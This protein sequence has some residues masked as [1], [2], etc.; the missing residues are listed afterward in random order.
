MKGHFLRINKGF[1]KDTMRLYFV[2]AIVFSAIS[3]FIAYAMGCD[4]CDYDAS[5][6]H[7]HISTWH[8]QTLVCVFMAYLGANLARKLMDMNVAEVYASIP[9]SRDNMWTAH[10]LTGIIYSIMIIAAS[11]IGMLLGE[12]SSAISVGQNIGSYGYSA[13][14]YMT[15]LCKI[16][17]EGLISFA[18][19]GTAF[20]ITGK[21]FAGIVTAGIGYGSIVILFLSLFGT[22]NLD[23]LC[24]LIFPFSAA[25]RTAAAWVVYIMIVIL[26][27]LLF[28]KMFLTIRTES[29][30]HAFRNMRI[31]TIVGLILA[32]SILG[33][34]VLTVILLREYAGD[35]ISDIDIIAESVIGTVIACLIAYFGFMWIS[36]RSFK[37]AAVSLK[38]LPI[39]LLAVCVVA[40][41]GSGL[42]KTCK[43][44]DFSA[45]NIAYYTIPN[46]VCTP[47]ET[48]WYDHF[49]EFNMFSMTYNDY[50]N[51]HYGKGVSCEDKIRFTDQKMIN[52][53]SKYLKSGENTADV[54]QM[55]G[56]PSIYVTLKNGKTYAVSISD[57]EIRYEDNAKQNEEYRKVMYDIEPFKGG[58][59]VLENRRA[60]ALYD[61]FME[62]LSTL[63]IEEREKL[64]DLSGIYYS[65]TYS[66][67]D[68]FPDTAINDVDIDIFKEA[69]FTPYARVLFIANRSNSLIRGIILN[70]STPKTLEAYLKLS[71]EL[72]AKDKKFDRVLELL[73]DE[74][75]DVNVRF[76][77]MIWDRE[78]QETCK[79]SVFADSGMSWGPSYLE[80]SDE[81]MEM[82]D[83]FLTDSFH[84]SID[85]L[86]EQE[87]QMVYYTLDYTTGLSY[88][89]Q[90]GSDE[91][92]LTDEIR[93]E[94]LNK[95][96]GMEDEDPHQ[97]EYNSD[98]RDLLNLFMHGGTDIDSYRYVITIVS[99]DITGM[100]LRDGFVYDYVESWMMDTA[101]YFYD[102]P[103]SFGIS[104]EDH[105]GFVYDFIEKYSEDL[106]YGNQLH[107]R[108][109]GY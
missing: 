14:E 69:K 6:M 33:A 28:R 38:Y 40:L 88:Y 18:F 64:F 26:F 32:F 22:G 42:R 59:F 23:G 25:V 7:F 107:Y 76:E 41:L 62:E 11:T 47:Y 68:G 101:A 9:V 17:L 53:I 96:I 43:N 67:E 84:V 106:Y 57:N 73:E 66:K 51:D 46:Y 29:Y 79:Y 85:E 52:E 61:T 63:T 48:D 80:I 20:S 24:N 13:F 93:R 35:A 60:N 82:M 12:L 44:V 74:D 1:F 83:E 72:N 30:S 70:E 16:M 81:E 100:E 109:I 108:G 27:L 78:K 19:L 4:M 99:M 71:N 45:D 58:H 94:D 5:G 90:V 98:A 37:K 49:I 91:E 2:S 36:S 87:I 50:F 97:R 8:I 15:E 92:G 65:D 3:A 102:Y 39:S 104:E 103:I 54:F 34:Y 89:E 31:Q 10:L 75:M 105:N 77:F 86:T 21:V 55:D 56:Q 95:L